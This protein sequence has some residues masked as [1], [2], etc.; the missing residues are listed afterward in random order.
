MKPRS[1]NLIF[2]YPLFSLPN[3][4]PNT[5]FVIFLDVE[6]MYY[7]WISLCLHGALMD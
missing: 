2:S 4:S 3:A 5:G 6:V 1:E 7:D